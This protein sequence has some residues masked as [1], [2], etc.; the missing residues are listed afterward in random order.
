MPALA[1]SPCQQQPAQLRRGRMCIRILVGLGRDA[2]KEEHDMNTVGTQGA[3][4]GWS[5]HQWDPQDA[6]TCSCKL[7]SWCGLL[8]EQGESLKLG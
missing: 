5:I 8:S 3:T 2:V 4:P 7:V 6:S 1:S